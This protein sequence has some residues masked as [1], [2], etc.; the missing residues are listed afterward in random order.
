M[1]GRSFLVAFTVICL[2]ALIIWTIVRGR[3][4]ARTERSDAVFGNPDRALGGWYWV[5]CG[6]S[7]VMLIWF[8]F[9]WD[10][11][12]AFVP[13]AANELCQPSMNA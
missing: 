9:S 8:Y 13:T 3:K 12:R 5:L 7:S 1:S 2:A 4:V 6:V 10:A 11:A